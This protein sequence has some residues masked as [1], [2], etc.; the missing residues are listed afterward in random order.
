MRKV[1]VGLHAFYS[2]AHK[3]KTRPIE[4]DDALQKNEGGY[5]EIDNGGHD[6]VGVDGVAG[7]S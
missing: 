7:C 1:V 2:V 6:L 4:L 3:N 5:D